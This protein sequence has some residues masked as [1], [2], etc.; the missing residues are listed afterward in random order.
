[1]LPHFTFSVS[2]NIRFR[3]KKKRKE[4]FPKQTALKLVTMT[5][6]G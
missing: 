5:Y 1:M 4:V 3:E 6:L 2:H